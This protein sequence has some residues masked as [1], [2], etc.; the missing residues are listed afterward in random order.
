M[1]EALLS[2]PFQMSEGALYINEHPTLGATVELLFVA[3]KYRNTTVNESRMCG[4]VFDGEVCYCCGIGHRQCLPA[5]SALVL[6]S[7][8]KRGR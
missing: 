1:L 5:W 4:Q 7:L 6:A 8:C 2:S 3:I